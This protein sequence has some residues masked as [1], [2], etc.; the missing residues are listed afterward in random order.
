MRTIECLDDDTIIPEGRIF[1]A[2]LKDINKLAEIYDL[3]ASVQT[4]RSERKIGYYSATASA[5][6]ALAEDLKCE[7]ET[8]RAGVFLSNAILFYK[9]MARESDGSQKETALGM[10]QDI[11]THKDDPPTDCT[12]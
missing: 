11:E 10:I 6:Q 4:P 7:G 9:R 1:Q 5:Y 8:A 3:C 2:D 12:E